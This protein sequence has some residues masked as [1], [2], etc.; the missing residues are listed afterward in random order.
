MGA[1]PAEAGFSFVH[2]TDTHVMAGLAPG[3]T[4]G[5]P[6]ESLR[7]VVRVVNALAP[8]PAFAVVGGDLVSPDLLDRERTLTA[9]DYEPSY[10]LFGETLAALRCPA[11]LLLGNHDH[12]EAF[13]RTL[14]RGPDDCDAPH[15][16]AF[17][18]EGCHFV[19][20]DSHEPGQAAGLVDAA[21]LA[22]LGTDLDAHR[23]RPTVVFVH[24]HV[25]PIGVA[26]LDAM[27][28]RN[29]DEL[30]RLLG[31]YPDV[32]WVVAGHVHQDH[33]AQ[34]GGLTV[35]TTPATS[36]Q[37][38]KLAQTRNVRP[39]PPAFRLVRVE[40]ATLASRVLHLHGDGIEAL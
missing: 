39:G 30:A 6:V 14:G 16:Y 3:T 37:I 25:W 35:V 26:W 31:G 27:A 28:L 38:S 12:R 17:D 5:D 33:H 10:R 19:A 29:G 11:H 15:R 2:L 22:W 34:R 8:Q 4:W 36:V 23:G 13:H 21:Q 18:H 40:G 24:H 20:L 7:R 9:Q 32:R 1:G